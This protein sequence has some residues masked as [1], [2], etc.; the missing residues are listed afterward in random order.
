[1]KKEDLRLNHKLVKC[2][3][4]SKS[5]FTISNRRFTRCINCKKNV[6]VPIRIFN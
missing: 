4:C 3:H 6:L 2:S 1:M 5:W